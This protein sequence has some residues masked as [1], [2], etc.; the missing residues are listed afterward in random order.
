MIVRLLTLSIGLFCVLVPVG[1]RADDSSVRAGLQAR[2]AAMNCR[3]SG[4][5]LYKY[6]LVRAERECL[7]N[8]PRGGRP[9]K[10]PIESQHDD[11]TLHKGRGERCCS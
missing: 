5:G 11:L 3:T 9:A 2:Y 8:D 7:G 6:R 10:G 1:A 4:S